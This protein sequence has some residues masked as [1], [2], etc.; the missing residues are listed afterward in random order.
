MELYG[1]KKMIL[2]EF[3]WTSWLFACYLIFDSRFKILMS[4]YGLV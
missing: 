4:T 3:N 1:N 2:Q